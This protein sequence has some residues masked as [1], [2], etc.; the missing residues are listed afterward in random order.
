MIS[1]YPL[2][3]YDSA[4][5]LAIKFFDMITSFVTLVLVAFR[6]QRFAFFCVWF[7][8]AGA[9]CLFS[10]RLRVVDV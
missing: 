2:Q 6:K 9:R 5:S 8:V 3:H 1:F 7:V 10:A 4:C